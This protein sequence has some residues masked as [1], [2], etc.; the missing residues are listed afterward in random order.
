MNSS[1]SSY[2]VL[3]VDDS[4]NIHEDFKKVLTR[5]N[6][7]SIDQ[8]EAE[9]FGD[10]V[11]AKSPIQFVVD[12]AYQ[13]E[14]GIAMAAAAKKANSSYAVA[15]VDM[16][17]PPGLDGLGTISKLWE[18]DPQLQV[19][20][21]S[22]YSDYSWSEIISKVGHNDR[23]VILRKPFDNIEVLQL[24][25]TLAEK[26]NLQRRVQSHLDQLENLVSER[27][28]E[29]HES[30]GLF[31]LI[32][33]NANDLISVIDSG[34][35]QIYCSPAHQRLL[36]FSPEELACMSPFA[37]VHPDDADRVKQ[38]ADRVLAGGKSE[39]LVTRWCHKEGFYLYFE[40]SFGSVKN[41]E[42]RF[43]YLVIMARDITE[44]HQQEIQTRLNQKLESIG[45][46]AAG[47]AHEINTPTQFISDNVRFLME[48][49]RQTNRVM[50]AY[51]KALKTATSQALGPTE[52]AALR[53]VEQDCELSYLVAEVPRTL[54]QSL[55]GLNRVAKIVNSLKEFSYP[56]SPIRA[57]IDLNHAIENALTVCRHEWKYVADV[58]TDF[59]PELPAVPCLVDELNQVIL[60]LVINASH[61]IS[62]ARPAGTDTKGTIT[63][64]TRTQEGWAV[65]SV[66][67]TGRGIPEAIRER[68]FEPFFTT[69]PMG[70]GTGQGL[71]IVRSVVVGKHHGKVN[72][73]TQ[74]GKG[75][76]FTI[77]LPL[78]APEEKTT[79]P[80]MQEPVVAHA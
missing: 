10:E 73:T 5:L 32:L 30:Q 49:F 67:D 37:R 15:F 20:I 3:I 64:K 61:A 78:A 38:A 47:I 46:L 34:R 6:D 63:V 1:S 19:V 26:W 13:G 27:T 18:V 52:L 66:A 59:D 75:T 42:G 21:C 35:R 22:A 71:T 44:R 33:E 14:E 54:D 62:D 60:N 48:A 55:E 31:R 25:H 2:R 69:K 79:R 40:A 53:A 41:D 50:E 51:Q 29:L 23:L 7:S 11:V 68:I 74:L 77:H 39:I 16:R 57:P 58:V 17:M 45:L 80:P 4:N 28:R 65:V 9:L 43:V 12:S 76:T 24:A 8:L 70:K 56:G 72:F 36:G